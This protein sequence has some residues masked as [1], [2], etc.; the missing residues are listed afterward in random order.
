LFFDDPLLAYQKWFL[1][2]INVGPA[3][4]QNYTGKGVNIFFHDNALDTGHPDISP[5][6]NALGSV[7][8]PTPSSSKEGHGTAVASFAAAAADNGVCGVGVAYDATISF[9]DFGQSTID[10]LTAGVADNVN[11][12]HSNSWNIDSC[13]SVGFDQFGSQA[14][15]QIHSA[16]PFEEAAA[17]SPCTQSECSG[18][19]WASDVIPNSCVNRI[20]RYCTHY[21]RYDAACTDHWDLWV[22]CQHYGLT[23][24]VNRLLKT[25]VT[26]GREGKGIIY[27]FAAGNEWAEGDNVNFDGWLNS[28]YTISVGALSPDGTHAYY[29]SAGSA[30]VCSAPGGESGVGLMHGAAPFGGC[31][32]IGQGT[33]FACPLVS[34]GVAVMLQANPELHWRDVQDIL[35]RTSVKV[36]ATDSGWTRNAAG[37]WHN[38]KYGFGMMDVAAAVQR[39]KAWGPADTTVHALLALG[40]TVGQPIAHGGLDSTLTVTSAESA[41]IQSIEH[42][43]LYITTVGHTRRGEL[44]IYLTSPHGTTSELAWTTSDETDDYTLFKFMTVRHWG[45]TPAGNWTLSVIDRRRNSHIGMLGSWRLAVYGKCGMNSTSKCTKLYSDGSGVEYDVVTRPRYTTGGCA[46]LPAWTANSVSC[47][48]SCCNPDNDPKGDWCF[49]ADSSCPGA[50]Q[51]G[52]WGYCAAPTTTTPTPAPTPAPAR[53]LRG[54]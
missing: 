19:D 4:A 20:A 49:L 42:V 24:G 13:K 28:I 8:D 45:E 18:F 15:L 27:V 41:F 2:A 30:V 7:G 36:D 17:Q 12:V 50:Q 44:A 1:E 51:G 34:G 23:N 11:H 48:E 37:L 22:S 35:I 25:G 29:S 54:P 31:G 16:C 26:I 46:C 21:N 53:R 33:S 6:Y 10:F 39:A 9:A 32:S 52:D 3:W 47:T 5:K 40:K 43:V 38:I 14:Y